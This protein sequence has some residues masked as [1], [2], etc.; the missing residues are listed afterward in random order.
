MA[1]TTVSVR[2]PKELKDKM[3]KYKSIID[4]NEELRQYIARRLGQLEKEEILRGVKKRLESIPPAPKG[5]AARLVR[6][7]RDSH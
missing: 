5:T 2:V 4:W 1:S 3:M 7:D 6:E